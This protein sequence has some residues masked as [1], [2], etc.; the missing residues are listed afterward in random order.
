MRR[1]FFRLADLI[2]AGVAA[3]AALLLLL[4]PG[5]EGQAAE[6]RLAGEVVAVL[7]LSQ[8]TTYVCHGVTVVVQDGAAYIRDADCPDKLCVKAG[9]L[10][11]AGDTAIC[12]PNR[13]TVT[14]TGATGADGVTY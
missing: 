7:P 9:R 5:G 14:V 6:V 4:L 8:D 2:P 13:V 10:T 11:K 1:P 3:A 12:L